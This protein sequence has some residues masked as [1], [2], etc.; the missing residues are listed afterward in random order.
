M[1]AMIASSD[2]PDWCAFEATGK[3]FSPTTMP[4]A[5]DYAR[6]FDSSPIAHINNVQTPLLMLLG[7][8]DRRVP[9]AQALD[10]VKLLKSR[11]V[12]T[13]TL[14]Y[15]GGQHGLSE[16]ASMEGDVWVAMIM[17]MLNRFDGEDV[18]LPADQGNKQE[19]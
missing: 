16:E 5:A 7:G 14:F 10:Y 3:P 6:M 13:R 15:A 12:R 9:M 4:T 19:A 1:A 18:T 11:G 8:A 2:I 17:W